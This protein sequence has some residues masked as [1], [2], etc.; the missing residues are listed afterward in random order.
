MNKVLFWDFD[1]TLVY[2]DHLWYRCVRQALSLESPEHNVDPDALR[3]LLHHGFPWH[4]PM[5]DYTQCCREAWWPKMAAKF[6]KDYEALG[7][8]SAPARRAAIRVRNSV[9]NADSYTLY[10]DTRA[11]LD[12][13]QKAGWTH[14]LLSNN[15]P[16][17][18]QVVEKLEL[19]HFFIGST[20]SGRIGYEKPRRELFEHALETAGRPELCV[21]IGDN[22]N[23]DLAGARAVGMPCILVHSVPHQDALF[24]AAALSEIPHVLVRLD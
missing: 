18:W 3:E 13:L 1:G 10:D 2:S 4:D 6:A 11:T 22:P 19:A 14:Y 7:V 15:Y 9:L 16:E 12:Y 21:M 5:A 24:N 8:A 20:I 23:A 17:L